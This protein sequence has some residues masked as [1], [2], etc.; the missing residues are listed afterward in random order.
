MVQNLEN[1]PEEYITGTVNFYGREYRVTPDVL[2]PRLETEGLVRRARQYFQHSNTPTL[3]HTTIVDI[4][5]GSGIIGTSV[6]DLAD[7]VIFLDISESAL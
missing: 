3:Q 1:Y 2:I 5:S 6:A 4:G 7:E